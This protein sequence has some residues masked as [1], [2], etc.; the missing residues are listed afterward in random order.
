VEE[1]TAVSYAFQALIVAVGGSGSASEG[2]FEKRGGEVSLT[3]CD[4][5]KRG[6]RGE[7]S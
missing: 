2:L 4:I 3:W 5:T 6:E 1:E 7:V